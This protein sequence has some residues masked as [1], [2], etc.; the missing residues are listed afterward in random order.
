MKLP[1]GD[2]LRGL[3]GQGSLTNVAV[4]RTLR[5][6]RVVLAMIVGAGLGSAGAALQ[7]ATRNGLAEPYLL[8]VSGGAAVGAVVAVAL[9][10]P[11]ALVPV[12]GF[13]GAL[14]AIALTLIVARAAGG[15][16]DARIVL[17]AGVVVGAFANAAIMVALANAQDNVVR[18]ALWWMMGSVSDAN[19]SQVR[20]AAIWVAVGI[21]ALLA[22]ARAIDVL[23]LGEDTAAGLGVRVARL[24]RYELDREERVVEVEG[25][26]VRIKVGLLGGRVVN[27]AP[28]HDDCA[29]VARASA[30]SVKS[31]WAEALARAQDA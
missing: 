9:H 12:A 11:A 15:Q 27:V 6:P 26:A 7:G 18:G 23:A 28:E 17:M 5:L 30:R 4:V 14:A 29:E 25:A 22:L 20:L 24:E 1:P 21:V 13:A 8:G 19:W 31:V 10:A 3:L 2:V 16:G